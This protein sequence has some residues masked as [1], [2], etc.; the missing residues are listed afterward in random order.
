MG[1]GNSF[2]LL[3]CPQGEGGGST[4][5]GQVQGTYPPLARSGQGKGVPQ[6][7]YS[8]QGTYPLAR[9]GWGEGVPTPWPRYLPP[10]RSGWRGST[11]RDLLPQHGPDTQEVVPQGTYPPGQDEGRGYPKLPTSPSQVRTGEGGTPR[12]LLPHPWLRTCYT[13]GGMPL[14]VTQEDFLVLK[15]IYCEWWQSC[16]SSLVVIAKCGWQLTNKHCILWNLD[17]MDRHRCIT[18]IG[19][20]SWDPDIRHAHMYLEVVFHCTWLKVEFQ[21]KIDLNGAF[22]TFQLT[23]SFT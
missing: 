3:V 19:Y 16:F 1:E 17:L 22:I 10:P 12:Y 8:G 9:S 20:S 21:F 5:P 14:A 18:C 23:L 7:T 11:P 13:V 6:G 4:Y 15:I 2:S